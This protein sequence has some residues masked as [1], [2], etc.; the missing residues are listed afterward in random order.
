MCLN[1]A[2]APHPQ[3]T[4]RA[5]TQV[6]ILCSS[7]HCQYR[8]Q[9]APEHRHEEHTNRSSVVSI[10]LSW[11]CGVQKRLIVN[12]PRLSILIRSIADENSGSSMLVFVWNAVGQDEDASS[13][14]DEQPHVYNVRGIGSNC[15]IRGQTWRDMH[16]S[17]FVSV[18]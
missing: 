12:T 4:G 9:Q 13:V 8:H 15:K 16:A 2:T 3:E 7:K 18:S 1:S 14:I 17:P 10:L 6:L 11:H 5:T